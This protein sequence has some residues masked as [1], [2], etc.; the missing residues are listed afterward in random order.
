MFE[1]VVNMLLHLIVFVFWFSTEW[2]G[3]MWIVLKS[4][5][6]WKPSRQENF[7][8]KVSFYSVVQSVLHQMTGSLKQTMV[9]KRVTNDRWSWICIVVSC[10]KHHRNI[11]IIDNLSS[12]PHPVCDVLTCKEDVKCFDPNLLTA[13]ECV[14]VTCQ[15]VLKFLGRTLS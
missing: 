15:V 4:V 6:F 8:T 9:Y 11:H 1:W 13:M 7:W 5:R 3:D 14:N 2:C 10:T 12:I